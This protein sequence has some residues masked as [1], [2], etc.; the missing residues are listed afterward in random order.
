MAFKR[1][2]K[3]TV[4]RPQSMVLGKAD[5]PKG[6]STR[7]LTCFIIFHGAQAPR[8]DLEGP[9][10]GGAQAGAPHTL[11]G[12]YRPRN[13][14]RRVLLPPSRS[15]SRRFPRT[16]LSS[17]LQL[18]APAFYYRLG[19]GTRGLRRRNRPLCRLVRPAHEISPPLPE[20]PLQHF[21]ALQ[22]L[23]AV[24]DAVRGQVEGDGVTRQEAPPFRPPEEGHVGMCGRQ[25]DGQ[26]LADPGAH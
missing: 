24:A 4:L 10:P 7:V 18:P 16:L 17:V 13:A 20:A 2:R 8:G 9:G 14:S 15:I 23:E 5:Q 25:D 21:A 26:H 19:H 22:V 11:P 12:S 1:T 3:R 6:S